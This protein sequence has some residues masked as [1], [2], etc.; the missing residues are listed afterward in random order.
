MPMV[1]KLD[2]IV[3]YLE[4]LL[5]IKSYDPLIMRS[6][7][8]RFKLNPLYLH[9]DSAYGHHTWQKSHYPSFM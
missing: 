9:K 4:E 2:R 8:S 3:A 5:P 6:Y 7:R 1:T